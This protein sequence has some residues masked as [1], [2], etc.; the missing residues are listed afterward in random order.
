MAGSIEHGRHDAQRQALSSLLA[1][2]TADRDA[3]ITSIHGCQQ[4]IN[5]LVARLDGAGAAGAA[6]APGDSAGSGPDPDAVRAALAEL[7]AEQEATLAKVAADATLAMDRAD[8]ALGAALG[9]VQQLST[10]TPD[11][12]EGVGATDVELRLAVA[13]LRADLTALESTAGSGAPHAPVAGESDLEGL[14]GQID[15]MVAQRIASIAARFEPE[16]A[17]LRHELRE[18]RTETSERLDA[19]RPVSQDPAADVV[20]LGLAVARLQTT[21]DASAA[22]WQSALGPLREHLA[23][24]VAAL[25]S[26]LDAAGDAQGWHEAVEQVKGE[27]GRAEAKTGER[28]E[29]GI[30]NAARGW[31]AAIASLRAQV[32]KL[33]GGAARPATA[34]AT[35]SHELDDLRGSLA[36]LEATVDARLAQASEDW[37]RRLDAVR[38]ESERGRGAVAEGAHALEQLRGEIERAEAKTGERIEAGIRNAARGWDGAL[39]VLRGQVERLDAGLAAATASTRSSEELS[40]LREEMARLATRIDGAEEA[41]ASVAEVRRTLGQMESTM[42][43][44]YETMR[45]TAEGRDAELAELRGQIE[46]LAA[47]LAAVSTNPAGSEDLGGAVTQLRN[48]LQRVEAALGD[49]LESRMRFAQDGWDAEVRLLHDEIRQLG[50][51]QSAQATGSASL[52]EVRNAVEQLRG[53]LGRLQSTVESRVRA[54]TEASAADT[55]RLHEQ[56]E[57]LT[58][59]QGETAGLVGGLRELRSA[60]SSLQADVARAGSAVEARVEAKMHAAL[61]SWNAEGR[62]LRVRLEQVAGARA[63][64]GRL[65]TTLTDLRS[66]VDHLRA[67]VGRMD[68]SL[69]RRLDARL[70][71]TEAAWDAEAGLLR[72]RIDAMAEH[73]AQQARADAVDPL[74]LRLVAVALGRR[75]AAVQAAAERIPGLQRAAALVGA[76]AWALGGTSSSSSR[77]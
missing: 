26:E 75:L 64:D 47:G 48:D 77:A 56:V 25:R 15:E 52:A 70:H 6:T 68:A 54:A 65:A 9:A 73:L 19:A 33:E 66:A 59:T 21:I 43:H 18:V 71:T 37:Q 50:E 7:R 46:R 28:I 39:G 40:T 58:A 34:G 20:A 13:Q 55:R 67:D 53:E 29:A 12:A 63:D 51:R 1:R 24:E 10:L 76:V 60:I 5:E 61:E 74:R 16:L 3:L 8:A 62:A 35:P 49:R 23:A 31:D 57:R 30:R 44:Y 27:L 69:D 38:E 32:E 36:R 42:G 14:R 72:A 4:R 41:R 11:G 22:D 45:T 17:G 2:F